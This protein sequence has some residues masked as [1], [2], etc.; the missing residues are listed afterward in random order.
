META[1]TG[2]KSALSGTKC[3]LGLEMSLGLI[4]VTRF[5]YW[6]VARNALLVNHR[7][8]ELGIYSDDLCL[9]CGMHNETH[10]HLFQECQYSKMIT[11][12]TVALVKLQIPS[13]NTLVWIQTRMWSSTKKDVVFCAFMNAHYSIWMQRNRSRVYNQIL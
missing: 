11:A 8:F 1:S 9:L 13:S 10:T 6:M 3:R 12:G 7:L 2:K 4:R 5:I